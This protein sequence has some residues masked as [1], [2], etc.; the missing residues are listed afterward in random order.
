M[1]KKTDQLKRIL[2][3][4]KFRNLSLSESDAVWQRISSRMEPQSLFSLIALQINRKNM[5]PLLIG[6][7][8]FASAGGTVAASNS[9]VPGDVLFPVDRAVENFRLAIAGNGKAK[10]EVKFAEERLDEVDKL[11]LRSRIAT[12]ATTTA[13]ST[14]TSTR[15]TSTSPSKGRVAVGVNVAI[16]YLNNV[17]A[18]LSAS[19]ETEAAAE[20]GALIARLETMVND[21]DVKVAL[22]Q[23]GDFML[24]IKGDVSA[25]STATSSGKIKINTSG[26]KSRIEVKEEDGKFKLEIKDNGEVKIKSETEVEM[27]DG[28]DDDNRGKKNDDEDDDDDDDDDDNATTSTSSILRLNL[29]R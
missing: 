19:G 8:I 6:A 17:A 29:R 15:A 9:A 3:D 11:I 4:L 25:S 5:I 14:A 16:E 27:E 1:K 28:N 23:N 10:L 20:I 7:L 2:K 21:P 12:A 26:N 18:D 24:K 22:K 13:T